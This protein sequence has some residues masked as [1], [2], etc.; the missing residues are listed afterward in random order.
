[1][2]AFVFV[3]ERQF[4]ENYLENIVETLEHAPTADEVAQSIDKAFSESLGGMHY[5]WAA[6]L[7]VNNDWTVERQYYSI[8]SGSYPSDPKLKG[9]VAGF[10]RVSPERW[11]GLLPLRR[12][13]QRCMLGELRDVEFVVA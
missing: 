1:M 9:C 2:K 10:Q 13:E 7:L 3:G 5:E 6:V 8:E 11:Y 4:S 12:V